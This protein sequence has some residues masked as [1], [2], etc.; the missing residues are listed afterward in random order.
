MS[1]RVRLTIYWAVIIA[2]LL[3]VAGVAVYLLFER[4]QW[5]ALDGALIEEPDTASGCDRAAGAGGGERR[6]RAASER[7]T[8]SRHAAAGADRGW[9]SGR[10]GLWRPRSRPA[11]G[12]RGA[13]GYRAGAFAGDCATGKRGELRIAIVPL[14]LGGAAAVIEDGVGSSAVRR[15]IARLR[16]SLLLMLPL[17]LVVAVSGG[18]LIAGRALVPIIALAD[19]LSRIDPHDMSGRLEAGRVNDEV[20]RLTRAINALLE[21]VEQATNTERR[22]AADA[23]HELRTPLTVLRTGLE[24]AL[25][26]ERSPGAY[27]EALAAALTEVV[28]LCTMA[29]QLLV[30]ARLDQEAAID[31]ER[32][33]LGALIG[34]VVEAVQPLVQGKPVT[35]VAAS[36]AMVAV[37]GNALH[38]KR[39]VIN[40]LD[41]AIKFTPAHGKVEIGV[42]ARGAEAI[43]RV[44]DRGPGIPAR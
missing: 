19:Q 6:N 5:G 22:F 39:L 14:E 9:R 28:A 25:G 11:R 1:I 26:R 43:V 30:V 23:A 2:A 4:Q 38:L 27:A 12:P 7:G 24:V 36:D 32:V 15:S 16:A 40:L 42:W 18:Y 20:A 8:R 10:N 21:R 17:I 37:E 34:E 41:N 44:A 3:V 35:L 31:R 13:S 29:D 33:D